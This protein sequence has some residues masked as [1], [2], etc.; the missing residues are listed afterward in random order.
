MSRWTISNAHNA[1][2]E[3]DFPLFWEGITVSP[4]SK[5][6]AMMQHEECLPGWGKN[7]DPHQISV[8]YQTQMAQNHVVIKS[9]IPHCH[10][11]WE[12]TQTFRSL[13]RFLLR[14]HYQII[15]SSWTTAGNAEKTFTQQSRK[16]HTASKFSWA[17][18]VTRLNITAF[19][20]ISYRILVSYLFILKNSSSLFSTLSAF[21]FAS[22]F[23]VHSSCKLVHSSAEITMP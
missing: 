22:S 13:H 8:G 16:H 9:L 17:D 12:T 11:T 20:S 6:F 3:W 10:S 23:H 18:K 14:T 1:S 5:K 4:L 19:P 7:K 2:Q 15:R 21:Y